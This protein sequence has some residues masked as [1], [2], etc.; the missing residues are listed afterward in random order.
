MDIYAYIP[1][2][3]FFTAE[4]FLL[5][6]LYYFV[7]RFWIAD[8]LEDRFREDNGSWLIDILKPATDDLCDTIINN[9][10]SLVMDTLK[11][12]LLSNQGTLTRISKADPSNE[13]EVGMEMAEMAL[14]SLGIKKP[15]VI[16]SIRMGKTLLG[17][18]NSKNKGQQAEQG[19]SLAVGKDLF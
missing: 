19:T 11:H 1:F 9:V 7:L 3:L 13:T 2:L 6:F 16:M 8:H 14:Q 12:E 5:L 17:M 18:Y 4:I 10:P 15:G